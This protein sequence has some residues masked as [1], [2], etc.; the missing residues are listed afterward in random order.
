[1]V[2]KNSV[3]LCG[4]NFHSFIYIQATETA[5]KSRATEALNIIAVASE[6][7]VVFW[8]KNFAHI[9]TGY[10]E[11]HVGNRES[12]KYA[13]NLC[14]PQKLCGPLWEKFRSYIFR[15][16]RTAEKRRATEA[17]DLIAVASE[18][19]VVFWGKFH[20]HKYKLQSVAHELRDSV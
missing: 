9:S 1:V 4:K 13:Q 3:V 16:Q 6:T 2:L 12:R 10:R 8:G 17:L 7:A 19:A 5:E 20:S 11:N 18:T 15:P 14:G